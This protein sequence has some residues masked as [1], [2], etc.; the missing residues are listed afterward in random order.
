MIGALIPMVVLPRFTSYVGAGSFTMEPM[1]VVTFDKGQVLF[2]RGP[3]VGGAASDPFRAYFEESHDAVIW[4]EAAT[5]PSQPVTTAD[6]SGTFSIH[7]KKR[8]FRI[9]VELAA[10]ASGVVAISLWMVGELERRVD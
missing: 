6:T 5:T 7:F 10:N 8:W 1:P 2:W 3:L 4:S 9:R